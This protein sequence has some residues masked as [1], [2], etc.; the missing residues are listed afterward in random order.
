MKRP[1][2]RIVQDS[3]RYGGLDDG[4]GSGNERAAPR[5]DLRHTLVAKTRDLADRMGM[6]GE[7]EGGTEDDSNPVYC[8]V[9]YVT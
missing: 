6:R 3:E 2:R 7:G 9:L 8:S 4:G 1:G 5:S